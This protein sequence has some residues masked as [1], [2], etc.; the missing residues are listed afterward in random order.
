MSQLSIIQVTEASSS[1]LPFIEQ[2][3]T[4]AFPWEERR[5]FA[6]VKQLL[7]HPLMQ[8]QVALNEENIPVGFA[9]T[10]QLTGCLFIEHIATAEQ[11]RSKGYGSAFMQA[12]LAV[13]PLCLL[14]I[15]PV[16]DSTTQRRLAFYQLY[17]F[18]PI[19]IV[20]YQP[21][22]HPHLAPLP[23]QLLSYPLVSQA[24]AGNI[25]AEIY[26]TVYQQMLS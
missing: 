3:Y 26:Q 17:G 5:D 11:H 14:E 9:I 21:P 16:T 25:I 10:W 6:T 1:F 24:H 8:V 7:A 4:Q 22:Y 20:Y 18:L 2:L 23:M 19:D 12:L 15:E 13:H